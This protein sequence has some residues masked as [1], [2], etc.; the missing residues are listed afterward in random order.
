MTTSTRQRTLTIDPTRSALAGKRILITRPR[1]RAA[2]LSRKLV[3]LGA[4]P[5]LFPTIEIAPIEDYTAL[6]QAIRTLDV[7][8]WLIF[9]SLNGVA[10][11][12]E[13]LA[14]ASSA[15]TTHLSRLKIAAVGPATGHALASRGVPVRFIPD[16][17]VADAI[18]AGM[19]DVAGQWI[20]F[21]CADIA[22]EVLT[23]E[24]ARRGAIV[25]EVAV[26]RTLPAAPD[27]QG[28]AE[29]RRGRG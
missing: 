3:D 11:F 5:I 12:W 18:V 13:R 24:L 23:L 17:Y 4:E 20:L 14:L 2:P 26:Y 25:H 22:R 10:A 1:T 9:T 27:P 6:D 29:L 15:R 7:Y 21:P 28:L 16:E 19:G 8:Q